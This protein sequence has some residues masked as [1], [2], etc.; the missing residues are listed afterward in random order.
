MQTPVNEPTT[1]ERD[2]LIEKEI[3]ITTEKGME[4]SFFPRE[5]LCFVLFGNPAGEQKLGAF[6]SGS[7][8][9][10]SVTKKHPLSLEDVKNIGQHSRSKQARKIAEDKSSTPGKK[11]R[12]GPP[13]Y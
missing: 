4:E 11:S 12:D 2:L 8:T 9:D 5:W 6:A 1:E 3:K 7:G 10:S 13:C